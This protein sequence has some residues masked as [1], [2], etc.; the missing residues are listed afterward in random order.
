MRLFRPARCRAS[1][2]LIATVALVLGIACSP[3]SQTNL[4]E[5][6]SGVEAPAA[7]R[8]TTT[9]A[10]DLPR[11]EAAATLAT[12]GASTTTERPAQATAPTAAP[13]HLSETASTGPR[14]TEVA[15][16]GDTVCGIEATGAILC[17][18]SDEYGAASPPIGEFVQLALGAGWELD[19]SF[20]GLRIDGAILCWGLGNGVQTPLE[21]EYTM[22]AVGLSHAC[23]L[24]HDGH[25][26]CWGSNDEGEAEAPAGKFIF[27]AVGASTTCGIRPAGELECWGRNTYGQAEPPVGDFSEVSLGDTH[28]CASRR[29][30]PVEC[31]GRTEHWSTSFF[32]ASIPEVPVTAL[33]SRVDGGLPSDGST[34]GGL[35]CGVAE[36]STL[37]CWGADDYWDLFVPEGTFT[38]VSVGVFESCAIRTDGSITCWGG[39]RPFLA[40]ENQGRF[41]EITAGN[42]YACGLRIRGEVIC[43]GERWSGGEP[44]TETRYRT[45]SAGIDTVCGVTYGGDIECWSGYGDVPVTRSEGDFAS[46]SVGS[47]TICATSLDGSVGCG[48]D[49]RSEFAFMSSADGFVYVDAGWS[50]ACGVRSD[51][52]VYCVG[53]RGHVWSTPSGAFLDVSVGETM[54]C[55][56]RPDREVDCWDGWSGSLWGPDGHFLSVSVGDHHACG[57][58]VDRSVECWTQVRLVDVSET[59]TERIS[60]DAGAMVDSPDGEFSSVAAGGEVSCGLKLDGSVVCWHGIVLA[61]HNVLWREIPGTTRG[62]R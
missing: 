24:P 39:Y 57:V 29:G 8:A 12:D 2:A 42:G 28:A 30:G 6:H 27:I 49:P 5:P 43:W 7:S 52:T 15:A 23:A 51:A 61:P 33:S 55:G 47:E 1:V 60:T 9:S 59:S 46:V 19:S 4:S 34:W 58:R 40:D 22:L 18:G 11:V 48:W 54:A 35:S 50:N 56:R 37:R 14:F 41:S 26:R 13:A 38:D 62:S 25:I 21:G 44:A 20:C 16:G 32:R 17:W 31:W 45:I 36:D 3:A 10:V 53:Y